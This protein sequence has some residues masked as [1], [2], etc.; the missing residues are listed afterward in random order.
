MTLYQTQLESPIGPLTLIAS[1]FGLRR[2][3]F[4]SQEST[5]LEAG[6]IHPELTRAA[7][8]LREYFDGQRQVFDLPLD[9]VGTD[10]QREAWRALA[11]VPYGET[12]SY[13]EQAQAIGRPG[14]YRAV[15]SANAKN[16]IPVVLPCHRIVG[17]NGS[18]T[19]FAGG[20]DLKRWLLA[21]EGA[22]LYP[23]EIL[24]ID[25]KLLSVE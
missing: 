14:A 23:E 22:N 9:L 12:R 21:H 13:G 25:R 3:A 11:A 4:S 5:T 20:L 8:Q 6:E 2:V 19:G 16:P 18:L 17:T 24:S 7:E 10:F 15:G 1:D